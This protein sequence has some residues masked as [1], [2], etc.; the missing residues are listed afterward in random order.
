[1]TKAKDE[2]FSSAMVALSEDTI[3]LLCVNNLRLISSLAPYQSVVDR[4]V[5]ELAYANV[6]LGI[7]SELSVAHIVCLLYMVVS[8][9]FLSH[10]RINHGSKRSPKY[11]QTL[12]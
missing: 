11:I 2:S 1:M 9:M 10:M 6:G 5:N 8:L 4:L 7:M 12:S 3:G